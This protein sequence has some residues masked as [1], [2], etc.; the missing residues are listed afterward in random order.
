MFDHMLDLSLHSNHEQY[1]KVKKQNRPE[2]WDIEYCEE[3]SNK[4]EKYSFATRMPKFKLRKS[5]RK[6]SK[7][8]I[9]IVRKY[10]KKNFFS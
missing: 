5:S 1:N 2:N 3:S 9:K 10:S 8:K 6:W 4:G 7:C